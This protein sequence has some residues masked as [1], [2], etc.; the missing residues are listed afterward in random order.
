MLDR[1]DATVDFLTETTARARKY[2]SSALGTRGLLAGE[3]IQPG[4]KSK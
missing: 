1:L 2:F 4:G 3:E